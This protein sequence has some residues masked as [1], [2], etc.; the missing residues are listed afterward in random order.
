ML[1]KKLMKVLR[2]MSAICNA[3]QESYPGACYLLQV[4]NCRAKEV[5]QGW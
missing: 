2:C 3:Q 4:L 1:V 5:Q